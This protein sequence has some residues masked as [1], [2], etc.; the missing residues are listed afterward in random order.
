MPWI[1]PPEMATS[2]AYSSVEKRWPAPQS[3]SAAALVTSFMLEAGASP[4]PGLRA[5]TRR[6]ASRS[7]T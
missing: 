7:H 3:M 6:A 2:G 1:T 5:Y 4:V